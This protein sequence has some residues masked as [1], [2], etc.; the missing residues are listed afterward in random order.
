VEIKRTV[1]YLL[2]NVF[3]KLVEINKEFGLA[4]LIV[5]QKVLE[6]LEI[7]HRVYSIKLGR[8][9]GSFIGGHL[10]FVI[11]HWGRA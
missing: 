2:E 10:S 6:V 7:C 1:R 4:M 3:K 8:V 11:G 5:E 9:G